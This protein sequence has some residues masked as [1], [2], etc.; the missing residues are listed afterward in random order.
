MS[1]VRRAAGAVVALCVVVVAVL[2]LLRAAA[3]DGNASLRE[4]VDAV[5]A[6]LRCPTCQGL[7]IADSASVLA[8]GSRQ[9]IEDQLRAGRSPDQIRQYFVDRYGEQVLLRPEAS[10]TGILVWLL[11]A[12]AVAAGGGFVWRWL[13]RARGAPAEAVG[14][15]TDPEAHRVLEEHR[16]GQLVLDDSP[17]AE[18]LREALDA[19]LAA[20]ED[21]PADA[22]ALARADRRLGAAF[23][24]YRARGLSARSRTPGAALPRRAVTVGAA[25]V[26][27][28]VAGVGVGAALQHRGAG[29]PVT[30]GIPGGVSAEAGS[31]IAELQARA[32]TRPQDPAAWVA[33]GRA[34]DRA[35][36]FDQA[37][38]AYD[39][40]LALEPAADVVV[41]LRGNVL[42][43]A[44]RA[45]EALPP[46]QEL[47]ERYP[48]D[49]DVLLVLGLAQEATGAPETAETLRRFLELAPDSPAAPGVRALLE[50][51]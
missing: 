9:V 5:A 21:W 20:E 24:R 45:A 22:E 29:E 3:P 51:Q 36:Q 11:P 27:L 46:M 26:L 4:Q 38:E 15:A 2:G 30:G 42:V 35:R 25:V 31:G 32:E 7:S 39:R 16:A 14:E 41:L 33:L 47:A 19:R 28:A 40:A 49:P 8:A 43:R 37:V 6:G 34:L 23:R 44:G 48:D 10:G 50:D 12:L 1:G 17:A 13:H 18:S